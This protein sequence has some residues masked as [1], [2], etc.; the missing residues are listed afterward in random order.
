MSRR[1][2]YVPKMV[3][4]IE[5]VLLLFADFCPTGLA[6]FFGSAP[7][8]DTEELALMLAAKYCPTEDAGR[9]SGG[10]DVPRQQVVVE[11]AREVEDVIEV[12]GGF[13]AI[14]KVFS[15][16]Q[17]EKPDKAR[18]LM[19]MSFIGRSF[20]YPSA[21]EFAYKYHMSTRQFYRC[22]EYAIRQ[23]AWEVYRRA[24]LS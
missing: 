3:A 15:L 6:C 4:K 14:Q 1:V 8:P 2:S 20:K 18:M 24:S 22:K 9:V 10:M 5:D 17:A 19:E 11:Q 23:I 13:F 16:Y 12:V 21:D 7:L